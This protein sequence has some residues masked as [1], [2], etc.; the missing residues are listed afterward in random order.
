MIY[1][2]FFLCRAL[3]NKLDQTLWK[4]L[5][6]RD[7]LYSLLDHPLHEEDLAYPQEEKEIKT[8]TESL[9]EA[10]RVVTD[11]FKDTTRELKERMSTIQLDQPNNWKIYYKQCTKTLNLN[12]AWKGIWRG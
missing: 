6:L 8:T 1:K 2:C 12:G 11:P 5:T 9:E 4:N 7:H 10:Q 3:N